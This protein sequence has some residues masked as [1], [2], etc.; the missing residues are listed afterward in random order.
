[1]MCSPKSYT[2]FAK[3]L[4]FLECLIMLYAYWLFYFIFIFIFYF[5]KYHVCFF[6]SLFLTLDQT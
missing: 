6:I 3:L 4:L 2:F 5:Y 1:M